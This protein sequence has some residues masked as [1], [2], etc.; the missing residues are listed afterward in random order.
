MRSVGEVPT[1]VCDARQVRRQTYGC[2]PSRRASPP[3]DRYQITL[4]GAR[5]TDVC[6]QLARSCL[7]ESGTTEIRTRDVLSRKSDAIT[8][9]PTGHDA[10]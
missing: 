6:E 2:L 1:E 5:G 7:P 10:T 8:T 9:T 4:V 3:L